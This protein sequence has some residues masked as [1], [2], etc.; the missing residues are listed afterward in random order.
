[1]KIDGPTLNEISDIDS[2]V[3][4]EQ[5][6]SQRIATT[7]PVSTSNQIKKWWSGGGKQI[8]IE[9]VVGLV[10]AGLIFIFGNLVYHHNIHL[11]EHDKDIQYLQKNDDKQD[12]DIEQLKEKSN[13]MN[14]DLRLIEQRLDLEKPSQTKEQKY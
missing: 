1:M 12:N 3:S 4:V 11:T 14:T 13:E 2:T 7:R 9:V 10:V 6:D 5:G 8:I